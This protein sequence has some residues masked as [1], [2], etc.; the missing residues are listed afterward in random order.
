MKLLIMGP[1]G[2][3]KG[4]QAQM[5]S[6]GLDIPHISAGDLFRENIKNQTTLGKEAQSYIEEGKLVP[7]E[8][9]IALI[10]DRFKKGDCSD[11]FILD[12][13][14]RNVA[15]AR[16]LDN[17]IDIDYVLFIDISDDEAVKRISGRKTCSSCGKVFSA[18][19]EVDTC[20]KCNGELYVRDDDKPE[21]IKKRL[22]IYHK[23]SSSLKDYYKDKILNIN[24]ERP[25]KEIFDE[26]LLKLKKK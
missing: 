16:A 11:G 21:T 17:I 9:T 4:T 25:I 5:I 26:I 24:G 7:D 10:E 3:G 20:T 18:S 6:E 1:Q 13:F 12:G 14:P 23:N 19:D 15:Q 22:E 8:V 2:C